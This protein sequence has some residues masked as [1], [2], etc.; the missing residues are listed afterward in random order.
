MRKIVLALS[1]IVAAAS[2]MAQMKKPVV[3]KTPAPKK[4]IIKITPQ[5][6]VTPTKMRVPGVRIKI[7]TD[8]GVII[9]RLS[10]STP[11]HRDNFVKLVKQGFYDSLMF[12]RVIREFMIQGGDPE[13]KNAVSGAML[14]NGGGDMIRIPAEIKP[15]LYHKRGVLAAARDNNPEKASSACQF[16]IVQGK[17]FTDQELDIAETRIGR[18]YS[19]TERMVYKSIGGTPWLDGG[20]TVFGEVESGIEVVDKI[21]S[22]PQDGNNRPLGDIRMRMEIL[23]MK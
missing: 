16:Y 11:L 7:T 17:K 3:K 15:S 4:N 18:K 20:Y 13:S 22:V 14:G 19:I 1:L 5:K 21:A 12:H 23:S 9:V 8:S 10:D 6:P 2:T